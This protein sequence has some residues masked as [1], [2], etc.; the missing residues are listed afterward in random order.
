MID[1]VWGCFSLLVSGFSFGCDGVGI[2]LWVLG[3][4]KFCLFVSSRGHVI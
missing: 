4:F 2:C 1:L 3:F